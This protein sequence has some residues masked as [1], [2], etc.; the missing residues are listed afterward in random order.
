MI[1]LSPEVLYSLGM[2]DQDTLFAE[3]FSPALLGQV[4]ES[5]FA[6]VISKG[7]DRLNGF[8]F[9][10]RSTVEL[11]IAS[12]KCSQGQYRFAPYLESLKVKGRNKEPRVISIP[13]IRDRVVLHQLNRFLGAVFPERIPRSIASTYVRAIAT[14]LPRRP[15]DETFVCGLDIK[16]FYDS[17]KQDRMLSTLGKEILCWQALRLISHALLTPTVPKNT[18][19]SRHGEFRSRVGVPQGLAISNILASIYL[20]DVDDAMKKLDVAYYRYVDDVLMYGAQSVVLKAE[21]SLR[22]RLM[23]RGLSLHPLTSSKSHFGPL[24]SPFGYLGY[25]FRWPSITVRDSTI[26]RFLQSIAAKFSDYGHNKSRRLEKFKYLTEERLAEIFL[27]EINERITGAI[28]QKKRYGWVAY[29]NQIT[30]LSLLH[31]LDHAIEGMFLRMHDFDYKPPPALKKLSRAYYEMKFNPRG[32][33]IRNYDLIVT[34]IE[35]L[36]FLVERGRTDPN[37]AL[38]DEQINDRYENY[39]HHIL[40]QMHA[41]EGVIY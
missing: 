31:R 25:T 9:A 39:R 33:Y 28:S 17:I 37:E 8:Q 10:R 22:S 3:L 4:F 24:S 36:N 7:S 30:D 41:D 14:D 27:L 13:T 35:K 19:K 32:T 16:R 34:Q 15:V 23:Y 2:I 12:A 5:N 21:K 6:K 1:S 11:G 38:T 26:E 29:F 18:H 20:K 40:A